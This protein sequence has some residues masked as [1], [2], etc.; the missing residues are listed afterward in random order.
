MNQRRIAIAAALGFA[1]AGSAAAQPAFPSARGFGAVVTGG[2]GGQVLHVT[3]LAASGTGSLAWAA[4][5]L[6][7]RYV[8]FDVSGV[9]TGDVEISRSD[10]TIAGQTAPGAGVTI[11]GHLSTPYG[12]PVNN[13]IVRHVRVRPNPADA[14][15]GPEQH[16][17][18]QFSSAHHIVLDHVDVSHGIDE[19]VD[20]WDGAHHVTVQ[21][22]AITFA[23]PAG[24]HPDGAHNFCLIN[25]D[26]ST[27]GGNAGGRISIVHNLFAHCR[28]RTPALSIGPAEVIGNVSYNVREGFVHHN[29]AY[30]DFVLAGNTYR[31]GASASLIPFWFDPEQGA[32]VPTRYFLG[33][34]AVD[35]P[36]VFTGIVDDPYASAAYTAAYTFALGTLQRSQFAGLAGAPDWSAEVGYVAA[37]RP[38]AADA[39]RDVLDCAGA[40]PRDAITQRAVTET[41]D[42]TGQYATLPV[43]DLLA[44]LVPGTPPAD[45]DRDGMPD[46]WETGH[47]LDPDL[48]DHA[49]VRPSGYPAIE[50]YLDELADGLTPCAEGPP[51]GAVDAGVSID[52]GGPGAGGSVGGCCGAARSADLGDGLLPLGLVG[53]ALAF[54]RRRR[55]GTVAT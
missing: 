41:R 46:A 29:A 45:R 35:D 38:A 53:L 24:G 32:P 10:I 26:G 18:I 27:G 13:I 54:R 49:A 50:D 51:G 19:N 52:G 44:G 3:T 43:N 42:R 9:I 21:W 11:N 34:N 28:T 39:Y 16:D 48:D 25:S 36:G 4:A 2:R 22:S 33:G 12:N 47:G 6:G 14:T 7:A 17:G 55:A 8:V 15:W 37:S 5:Q 40:W 20:L 31:D 23:N 1:S 30:G